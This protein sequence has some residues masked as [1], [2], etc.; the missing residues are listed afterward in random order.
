MV[1]TQRHVFGQIWCKWLQWFEITYQ[2]GGHRHPG[3][4]SYITL[5]LDCT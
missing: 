4:V 2:D 1:Y 5:L 3:Q